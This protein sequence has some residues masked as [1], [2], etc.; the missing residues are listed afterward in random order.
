MVDPLEAN[1][2]LWDEWTDSHLQSDFYDVPAFLAGDDP[3]DR[4]VLDA[5]GD[6]TGKRL[7]HLQCHFG[8]DTLALARRGAVATGVD[9]SPKAIAAARALASRAG[10]AATFVL[11]AVEDLPVNLEGEFDMVFTGGGALCWL[12]DL[13]R[14]AEV[15]AHFL[16]PGGTCVIVEGHPFTWIFDNE[17]DDD[18][19][20][21]DP[22]WSYFTKEPVAWANEG[23]YTGDAPEAKYDHHYEW[24]H[25]VSGIIMA[26]TNAGLTLETFLEHPVCGFKGFPFLVEAGDGFW[27]TP[28]GFPDL[29][30]SFT[31]RFR[32]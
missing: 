21:P 20:V 22:R 3:L 7:L 6:V 4:I 23:S 26:L 11:S 16:A 28:D 8:M 2:Q 27:R 1:R 29:P 30:V 18:R 32:R 24:M 5:I 12:G 13:A 14:W 31:M 15:I 25:S 19:L 9:F 17:R 10:L